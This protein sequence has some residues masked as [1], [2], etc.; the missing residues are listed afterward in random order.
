[1]KKYLKA[2]EKITFCRAD[3]KGSECFLSTLQNMGVKFQ[4]AVEN[5]HQGEV[6]FVQAANNLFPAAKMHSIQL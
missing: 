4:H 2:S 5:F 6:L 1:M 3:K